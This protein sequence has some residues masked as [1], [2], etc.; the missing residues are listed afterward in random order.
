MS[1]HDARVPAQTLCRN[2]G[3]DLLTA[4]NAWRKRNLGLINAL[5]PVFFALVI[6]A[7]IYI[8]TAVLAPVPYF[9]YYTLC[10]HMLWFAGAFLSLMLIIHFATGT[11]V[12]DLLILC[13][14]SV[15]TGVPLLYLLITGQ[16][17]ELTYLRGGFRE[18]LTH[19]L[20]FVWTYEADRALTME[21]VLIFTG[22]TGLAYLITRKPGKA[23][24]TGVSAYA[25]LMLWAVQWV[26]KSPHKYAVFSINT[27]MVS[28]CLI[29][30]V[31]L[32][33]VSLLVAAALWRAGLLQKG[34]RV[35]AAAFG[36][37]VLAW[38]VF[39]L[40]MKF[41]QWFILPFDIA[42][43]GLA[44]CTDAIILTIL[45]KARKT[46]VS[47]IAVGAFVGLFFIQAAVMGPLLVRAEEGLI[48]PGEFANKVKRLEAILPDS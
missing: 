12:K 8:E 6:G 21:L 19:A 28:N 20:T 46:G 40:I 37:G 4:F 5:A 29:A 36:A 2:G 30:V 10:H 42:V 25:V 47:R 32:H 24:F 14:G 48:T 44:V 31:L 18:I 43:S 35:W 17:A 38:I 9:S 7:R 41:T 34:K 27:W 23:L 39:S 3:E 1:A 13:Y 15:L 26:G 22:I 33:V 11:P 45:F 16:N